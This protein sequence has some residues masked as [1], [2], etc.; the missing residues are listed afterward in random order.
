MVL[1][2]CPEEILDAAYI[3]HGFSVRRSSV[4]GQEFRDRALH[5]YLVLA[6]VP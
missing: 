1:H 2:A 3:H 5:L 6:I 4:P